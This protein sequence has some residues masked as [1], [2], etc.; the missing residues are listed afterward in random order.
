LQSLPKNKNNTGQQTKER[1]NKK[2]IHFAV[3]LEY[4][5]LAQ[6]CGFGRVFLC[7][8]IFNFQR[9]SKNIYNLNC[10]TQ[11]NRTNVN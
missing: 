6:L 5:A 9:G 7:T 3:G 8:S 1:E 2:E 10:L 11:T 4:F